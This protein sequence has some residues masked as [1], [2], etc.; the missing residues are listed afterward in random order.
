MLRAPPLR[1]ANEPP[2]QPRQVPAGEGRTDRARAG[3]AQGQDPGVDR[4]VC[5]HPRNPRRQ[6]IRQSRPIPRASLHEKPRGPAWLRHRDR[7][8]S[9]QPA[10]GGRVRSS[11]QARHETAPVSLSRLSGRNRIAAH[12]PGALPRGWRR[13]TAGDEHR[14]R[15]RPR[16]GAAS[17][18]RP[19]RPAD[20][21]H[22]RG[23]IPPRSARAVRS[24]AG[25]LRQ[26][27]E[28]CSGSEVLDHGAS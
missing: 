25:S 10:G 17:L 28:R 27:A 1:V 8:T 13:G 18:A 7:A 3:A 6:G 26:A 19:R 21:P 16:L 11:G 4:P 14:D 24:S 5:M 9:A 2:I 23:G 22:R 12:L 15:H 20:E